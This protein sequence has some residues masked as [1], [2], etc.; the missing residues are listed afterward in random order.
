MIRSSLP[1]QAGFGS[2]LR[3]ASTLLYSTNSAKTEPWLTSEVRSDCTHTGKAYLERLGPIN[4]PHTDG[5]HLSILGKE[6]LKVTL[7]PLNL[8]TE[9]LL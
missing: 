9:A 4:T 2:A 3:N 6:L 8:F 1:S 7:K 5:G